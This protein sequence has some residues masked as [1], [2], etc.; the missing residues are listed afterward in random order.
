VV[1][2]S[3]SEGEV[4]FRDGCTVTYRRNGDR[5]RASDSCTRDQRREADDAMARARREQG[6][7]GS[8]GGWK[9]FTAAPRVTIVDGGLG[10]AIYPDGCQINYDLLGER[11]KASG[12]CTADQ[13]DRADEAMAR[14]RAERRATQGGGT[15]GGASG[16]RPPAVTVGSD[17][18]GR[19]VFRD[20]CRVDYDR[21]GRRSGSDSVCTR[22]QLA[23][24][25][26]AMEHYRREHGLN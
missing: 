12:K 10:H 6:T 21:R 22:E 25:D 5:D 1:L 13:I 24:A 15:S 9:G 4:R 3:N 23:E 19:V 18:F 16:G 17:G 14:L 8:G 2:R 7:N 11:T 26:R 20:G